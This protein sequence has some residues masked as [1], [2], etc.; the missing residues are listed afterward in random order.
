MAHPATIVES[1][2]VPVQPVDE[3]APAL[4]VVESGGFPIT[5]VESGGTPF[6]LEG[7]VPPVE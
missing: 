5:V 1:G 3:N 6:I 4:T 2:G 7:Y